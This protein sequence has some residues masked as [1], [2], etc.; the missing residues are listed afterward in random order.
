MDYRFAPSKVIGAVLEAL[1]NSPIPN[2]RAEPPIDCVCVQ[3]GHDAS[4]S[5]ALYAV[6]YWIVDVARDTPT[7]SELRSRVHAA[8]RRNSIPM[9]L[10]A[11]TTFNANLDHLGGQAQ[12]QRR[13][14]R[15]YNAVRGV[16]LFRSLTDAEC[17]QLASTV[18][19][20]PFAAG[21]VMTRQGA[22]A[23][24]LYLVAAGEVEVRVAAEGN[25]ATVS[26]IA[27]PGFFG[28]MG[29]LT[30]AP[31]KASVY[32]TTATECFKM[33]HEGFERVIHNRPE[34][35]RDLAAV[36]AKRQVELEAVTSHVDAANRA[37][38][39]REEAERIGERIRAFFGLES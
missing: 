7:D 24:H 36:L 25:E 37:A 39:E 14:E 30:G 3:L 26:R 34:V 6:R 18:S 20:Y 38:K 17:E 12:R 5:T 33:E 31:R 29:L 21:E 27:A 19:F 32:A 2:V 10:P 8:L 9:A 4:E 28:E 23:H 11:T 35:A 1:R 15:A 16:E 13:R 22:V